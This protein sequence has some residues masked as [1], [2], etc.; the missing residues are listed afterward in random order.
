MLP[1]HNFIAVIFWI[2][3]AIAPAVAQT[4]PFGLYPEAEFSPDFSLI[5]SNQD[6]IRFQLDMTRLQSSGPIDL[7]QHLPGTMGEMDSTGALMPRI[8]FYLALPATGNPTVTVEDWTIRGRDVSP[9]ATIPDNSTPAPHVSLEDVGIFGGVRLVPVII[10]PI[11][12]TN[13]TTTCAVMEQAVIRIDIDNQQGQNPLTS[14]RQAYSES[15]QKVLKAVVMNWQDIPNLAVTEPSHILF[16]V[17]DSFL[18][19]TN[20]NAYVNWKRQLGYEVTVVPGSEIAGA[21][22][23]NLRNRVLSELNA[24]EHRVDYV[25][26]A[27]DESQI[28]V[29]MLF[30]DDPR[31]RFSDASFPGEFTEE[32]HYTELEGTDP[33]PDVFLGRWVVNER[34]EFVTVTN[35]TMFHERTPF[36]VDSAR[37]EHAIVSADNSVDS[38]RETIADSRMMLLD[39][40]FE[41]VDTVWADDHPSPQHMINLVNQ[42]AALINHRGSGWNQGW[43]GINFYYWTVPELTNS[44]M[45]IIVTGIGCGVAKFDASNDQCFGEVWMTH[46]SATNPQG[47]VGFIGPCWNTHTIY[48]NVLDTCIYKAILDYDIHSLAPALVAGKMFAWAVFAD[49]FNEAPVLEVSTVMMRQYLVLSDPTL[50]VYT[51][52]PARIPVSTSSVAQAS[53]HSIRIEI[54][55]GFSTDTDSLSFSF[56]TPNGGNIQVSKLAAEAGTV[57]LPVN[58]TSGDTVTLTMHGDNIL[59]RQWTIQVDPSGVYLEHL[60]RS[61]SDAAGNGD[62]RLEP[63]ESIVVSDTVTNW[64][65]DVAANVV[66]GLS[67]DALGIEFSNAQANYGNVTSGQ[68]AVGSPLYAFTV[69]SDFRGMSL[70]LTVSYSADG[71]DTRE[72][73]YYVSVYTPDIEYNNLTVDDGNNGLLER[74]EPAGLSFLVRNS[75]N[76]TLVPSTLTLTTQS[77]YINIIDGTTAIPALAPGQSYEIP[78]SELRVSG[79]WNAPTGV[80]ATIEAVITAPMSTYQF[81]RVLPLTFVLGQVGPADPQMGSDELYYI[82]D[83]LDID[84]DHAAVYDWFEIAPDA[85]GPGTAMNFEIS[86]QTLSIPVPFNY[87][88]FGQSFSDLS[89][90]TDGWVAPGVTNTTN[91]DNRELPFAPDFVSGMIAV[92]WQDLWYW[93][94]DDG[95]ICYYYDAIGDRFIV[96]WYQISAWNHQDFPNTFQ[97]QLLNPA[98]HQTPTGDAEWLFMYQDLLMQS[99]A[100][101]GAT[102]GYESNDEQSGGTY[103]SNQNYPITSTPIANDLA[104]RLTTWPPTIADVPEAPVEVPSEFALYQNY[105]NP[106]NPE[107]TIEFAL[108]IRAEVK[109]EIYDVLGRKVATLADEIRNAGRYSI[110]WNGKSTAGISVPSGIYFYRLVTPEFMQTKR[111]LLMR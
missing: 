21:S 93:F 24:G 70:P 45:P 88:Y 43:A 12:Y 36:A 3:C 30:T 15:W 31:T 29:H 102:I 59:T 61:L 72:S 75:G 1:K 55:S 6:V 78:S 58:F 39:E 76:E 87:S 66:G 95:Q 57:N 83:N 41:T 96:E 27:G 34:Q 18:V 5:Q 48:N 23:N 65:S 103:Y 99:D 111:M 97:V 50:M 60:G 52:T 101:L 46:G 26:L 53:R 42:G 109:L 89:V 68:I 69:T 37:F 92:M 80:Q 22:G 82:Y 35:K 16:V 63:G 38:Q 100:A 10:R 14:I 79:G 108:A 2:A 40:G 85:G 51:D 9:A 49:F 8:T 74:Y 84:Y 73:Q 106:F 44:G 28:P 104:I 32:A 110:H 107:T 54:A 86:Q 81:E 4:V 98:T 77:S 7:R 94:G 105:P 56:W 17:P 11:T 67:T 47:A 90:S 19:S 64:G 25:I 71:V 13:N 62:G 91:Y 33:F 20:I